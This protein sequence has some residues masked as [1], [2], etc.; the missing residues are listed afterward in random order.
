MKNFMYAYEPQCI[1]NTMMFCVNV[2]AFCEFGASSSAFLVWNNEELERI[3]T[4][5]D[6]FDLDSTVTH[7][8][9]WRMPLSRL[10]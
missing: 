1:A 9:W 7:E 10:L 2:R 4:Y 6:L 8:G 5:F 3:L